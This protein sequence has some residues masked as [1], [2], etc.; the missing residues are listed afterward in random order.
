MSNPRQITARELHLIL[1][2]SH[3]EFGML[4]A[5]FYAKWDV[6]YE[7]MALI[8]SRSES[9]VRGWFRKGKKQRH[10]TR[11]DSLHL[12]FMDLLL[13]H[14]EEIPHEVLQ[15]LQLNEISKLHE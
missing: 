10:P 6:S 9:T 8:C 4:P 13:E 3:W 12:A 5:D 11:N 14:F 15:W 7:Q 1:L 2:Y